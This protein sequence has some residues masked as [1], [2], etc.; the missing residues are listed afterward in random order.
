LHLVGFL[1][2]DHQDARLA[3]HEISREEALYVEQSNAV[4]INILV[5]MAILGPKFMELIWNLT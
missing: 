4:F 5:F 1:Y 3:K 2:T